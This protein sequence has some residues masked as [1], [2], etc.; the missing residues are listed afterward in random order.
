[1]K[2]EKEQQLWLQAMSDQSRQT[3][4]PKLA[5]WAAVAAVGATTATLVSGS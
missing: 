3:G 1:M 4:A 2:T 5:V